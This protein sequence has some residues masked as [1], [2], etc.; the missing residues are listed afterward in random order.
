MFSGAGNIVE[1]GD[2]ATFDEAAFSRPMATLELLR[3]AAGWIPIRPSPSEPDESPCEQAD[4]SP[5]DDLFITDDDFADLVLDALEALS[6]FTDLTIETIQLR[7]GH[8][9]SSK[10]SWR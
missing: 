6:E 9:L 1:G 10:R 4:Q 3:D 7:C 2:S 8:L 5:V